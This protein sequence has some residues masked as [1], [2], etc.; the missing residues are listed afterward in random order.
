MVARK[1]SPGPGE[2]RVRAR[3]LCGSCYATLW[4]QGALADHERQV[5][6]R[7]ELAE[8]WRMLADRHRTHRENA[9]LIA[10]RIG[11]TPRALERTMRR[12]RRE[13]RLAS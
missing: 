9:E 3:G 5:L 1:A 6:T 2:V 13:A 4:K 10:P 8:E 12:V 11:T 7:A